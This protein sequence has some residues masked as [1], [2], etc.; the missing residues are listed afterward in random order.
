MSLTTMVIIGCGEMAQ[1]HLGH[2]LK[3]GNST[4]VT[5]LVEPSKEMIERTSEVFKKF[6]VPLPAVY[7]RL[8]EFLK[9]GPKTETAFIITPHNM[10]FPQTRACLEAGKDVLLEKPMVMNEKEA[11]DL[12]DARNKTGRLL[13]VAFPGSLSPAIHKVKELIAENAIGEIVQVAALI[14]QDW[15]EAQ[16]GKWRQV[17]EISGGGFLFDTGSHMINTVVDILNDDIDTV[18]AI[19]DNKGTPVDICSVITAKT[20]SGILI[21]LTGAGFSIGCDSEIFIVGTK[22]TIRTGAWGERLEMRREG[23]KNLSPVKF[24]ESKGVWEQFLKV[25]SGELENPCPPEVGLRFARL[26]D[27]INASTGSGKVVIK[28]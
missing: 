14:Y 26:M 13:V 7:A 1:H 8:D 11:L 24:G 15:K 4:K 3:M 16:K 6:N 28:K 21:N 27:M 18:F 10:H 5:A 20:T 2:I 17:P 22:G 25:R 12:I 9:S 19:Q 23:E